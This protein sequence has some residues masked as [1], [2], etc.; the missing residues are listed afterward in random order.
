MAIKWP[1]VCLPNSV[2]LIFS[3]CEELQP[4]KSIRLNW[5]PDYSS[6]RGQAHKTYNNEKSNYENKQLYSKSPFH[7]SGLMIITSVI[8]VQLFTSF[9]KYKN[10]YCYLIVTHKETQR[11]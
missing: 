8:V 7:M 1:K 4:L 9:Q 6:G 3:K 2:C 11:Y 5:L 10:L